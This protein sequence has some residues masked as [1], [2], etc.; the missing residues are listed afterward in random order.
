MDELEFRRRIYA[1]PETTDSDVVEAAKED[2][3]KRHFW[4]EQKKL[5]QQLKQALKVDV[6]DDLANKLIWQP[7]KLFEDRH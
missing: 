3:K 2:E 1:D 7:N 4:N 5:D 6:P